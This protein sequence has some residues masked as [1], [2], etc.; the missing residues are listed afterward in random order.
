MPITDSTRRFSSR[1]DNYIRY[2]PSYPPAVLETMKNECGLTE[3]AIIADIGSGTGLLSKIFL[4]DGNPVVGVEPNA[5][6]RQAG[7]Q[8]L[9]EYAKF[10]SVDGTAEATT[11]PDHSVDFVTAGQA[12]HWF[13]LEKA[14]REF[15]R[16]LKPGGWTVLI[17]NERKTGSTPF[18][19]A[20]ENLLLTCGTDYQEI[21]HERT[22]K[23]IDA[24]FAHAALQSKVFPYEQRFDYESLQGRLLS[25]SYTPQAGDPKYAPMLE[26]LRRMFDQYQ[27]AGHVTFEYDTRM[28]YGKL[29]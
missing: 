18:L 15:V 16:I 3:L 22:S 29:V 17:W 21:R 9:A 14:R 2:R 12:A 20:Y 24:F 13:N 7:E 23:E 26:E 1:V 10:T 11:L 6:M 28:F 27:T 19:V 4:D 8:F 25:S 5:D